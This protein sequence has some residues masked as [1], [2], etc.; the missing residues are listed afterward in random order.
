MRRTRRLWLVALM[1]ALAVAVMAAPTPALALTTWDFWDRFENGGENRWSSDGTAGAAGVAFSSTAFS[2]THEAY[3]FA[4]ERGWY[5]LGR[6]VRV[7]VPAGS[8]AGCTSTIH[9]RPHNP[10]MVL[11]IEA[12]NPTNWTY[13]GVKTVTLTAPA[14]GFR[15]YQRVP[16]VSWTV[17]NRD[18]F[19]RVSV[20]SQT[21]D[22]LEL[23]DLD[24]VNIRCS[25]RN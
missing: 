21:D 25:S 13:M 12:I 17:A 1:A 23:I 8:F 22:D 10:R 19:F 4:W 15:P 20:I 11:N 5:S 9:V 24:D 16:G 6:S 7:G 3:I 2:P 18:V 14:D